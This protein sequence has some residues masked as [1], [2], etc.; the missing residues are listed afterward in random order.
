[1]QNI[2]DEFESIFIDNDKPEIVPD[3][4]ENCPSNSPVPPPVPKE[5]FRHD[6]VINRPYS[7]KPTPGP[8]KPDYTVDVIDTCAPNPVPNTYMAPGQK[9]TCS[10]QHHHSC[11][12]PPHDRCIH[13]MEW[14]ED[15]RYVTKH[16]LNR[17]LSHIADADIF[18]D[19]S[20]NGTTV[21]VGGIKKGTKFRKITFS[22]FMNLLLYPSNG[23]DDEEYVCE[24]PDGKTILN[25]TVKY[26]LGGFSEGDSLKGM[27][28]SKIIE[29]LLCGENNWG[30]YR[31]KSDA[32]T[33]TSGT[34]TIEAEELFPYLVSDYRDTNNYELHVISTD[35]DKNDESKW[36]YN[37]LIAQ[38]DNDKQ[39]TYITVDGVP[40][41]IKWSYNPETK[42]ITLHTETEI[43]ADIAVVMI[44]K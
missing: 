42:K 21:S 13:P 44:R 2:Y 30:I 10:P 17:I 35:K 22:Q 6:T 36:V 4:P 24:T 1:M 7:D 37:N 14:Q 16:E 25:S 34:T 32:I 43:T 19:L 15:K 8:F 39:K 18:R 28:I 33:I 5:Y 3:L 9:H 23:A 12:P 26:P 29:T 41:D 27:T 20:I 38:K 11:P 40:S 31:W